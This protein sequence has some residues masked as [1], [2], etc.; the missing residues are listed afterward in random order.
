LAK[1]KVTLTPL[2]YNLTR[3]AALAEMEQ[4]QFQMEQS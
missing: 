3:Q 1:G 2:D 4:W